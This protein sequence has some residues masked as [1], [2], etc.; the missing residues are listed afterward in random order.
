MT[1]I[2]LW[3]VAYTL[4]GDPVPFAALML[5]GASSCT[6][7]AARAVAAINAQRRG[8][9]FQERLDFWCDSVMT[10]PPVDAPAPDAPPL[11]PKQEG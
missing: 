6:V 10:Q 1:F 2:V 3:V 7:E 9:T 8:E 11:V 4:A 5:P